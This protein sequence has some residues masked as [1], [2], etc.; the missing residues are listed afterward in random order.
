MRLTRCAVIIVALAG[1]GAARPVNAQS[2][3]DVARQE[4]ERRKDVKS[5]AKVYTNTDLKAPPSSL[6]PPPAP[7]A[8][9]S[10]SA[11]KQ[12]PKAAD[13]KPKEPSKDQA[14]WAGRKKEL[15]AKLDRDKVLVEAVQSR[16]NALTADFSSRADPIQRSGIGRDRQQAVSELDRLQQDIKAGQKALT[17]LDEEAR[18]AG[19]PPGWLR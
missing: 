4:E 13:D 19:V 1:L 15:Q 2:L 10:S 3:G 14:Y 11:P 6:A 18:K 9:A 17:D 5:P 7:G 16:I 12:A 8:A